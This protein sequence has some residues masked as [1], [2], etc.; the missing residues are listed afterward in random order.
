MK[1]RKVYLPGGGIR[2]VLNDPDAKALGGH[3]EVVEITN[4][5]ANVNR[6]NVVD[7]LNEQVEE[8]TSGESPNHYRNALREAERNACNAR[9]PGPELARG[10]TEPSAQDGPGD[11]KDGVRALQVRSRSSGYIPAYQSFTIDRK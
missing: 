5:G 2:W 10:K 6:Q 9:G 3:I 1:I 4:P 7:L 11:R 8:L